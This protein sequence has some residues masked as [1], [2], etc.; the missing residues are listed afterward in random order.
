MKVF[1]VLSLDG[2]GMRGVYTAEFLD[3]M[4]T[5]FA[6]VRGVE[7]LD[8]GKGFDLITGTSTG[9]IVA[10]AAAIGKPMHEVV[11]LYEK[12]GSKIF[13]H[14][15]SGPYS[16]LFRA[17]F[18]GRVF[19]KQGDQALRE[20]LDG[21]LRKITLGEVY[22]KRQ[23][24]LSIP[25]VAMKNHQ[26]WVFKKTASS[27][28]R[29]DKFRLAD[30]CLAS[31]AAPIYRSVAAIPDPN[32]NDAKAAPLTFTDGGLW[33]N[34]PAMVGL[35]D[36]LLSAPENAEIQVF[37]LGTRPRPDGDHFNDRTIHRSML[38]WS[39]GAKIAPV[40]I[41]AQEY[42]YDNMARMFGNV[43]TKLGRS[44]K[45]VRFP[46]TNMP[47]DMMKYL[48]LD[49]TRPIAIERLRGQAGADVDSTKSACDDQNNSD[50]KLIRAA[51][52]GMPS[53]PKTGVQW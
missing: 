51:F 20:A 12:H 38:G 52:E 16:A 8:I 53:M 39:L 34:N 22:Q 2:G 10:C 33:A 48:D 25:A 35:L 9:A 42:A 23:I 29:D 7:A 13:P 5:Y 49:D 4:S 50:G 24:A 30:I 40:G 18:G 3:R 36:A 47:A 27:G 17:L 6:K 21:V 11:E 14:R 26:A 28:P 37:A 41:A 46:K 43:L 45:F 19:V 1:R 15:I 31:S 32:S 44:V